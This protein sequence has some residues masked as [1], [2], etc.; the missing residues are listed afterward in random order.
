[1]NTPITPSSAME[2]ITFDEAKK[3]GLSCTPQRICS[4]C[5]YFGKACE[6]AADSLRPCDVEARKQGLESAIGLVLYDPMVAITRR[7]K[8]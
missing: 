2:L 3:R 4:G 7:L 1:M 8:A 6:T 5:P